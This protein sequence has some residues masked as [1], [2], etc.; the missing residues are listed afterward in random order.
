MGDEW[1]SSLRLKHQRRMSPVTLGNLIPSQGLSFL[2][3]VS[4]SLL[5]TW[6]GKDN[7]TCT[8]GHRHLQK[9][10]Q[11]VLSRSWLLKILEYKKF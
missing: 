11:A 9:E 4:N 1:C 10:L 5:L 8:K 2:I 3:R 7:R 6:A